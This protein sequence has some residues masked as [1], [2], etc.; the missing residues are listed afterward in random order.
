MAVSIGIVTT[1]YGEPYYGFLDR[2]SAAILGLNTQ[3][4]WITIVH[5][6]VPIDVQAKITKRL[7]PTWILEPRGSVFHPQVHINIGIA[8]TFTDWIV[9]ADVDDLLL[10][11][12]L[13]GV[14]ESEADILSFGYRVGDTDH[15]SRVVSAEAVLQKSSNA[16]GSCSPFR[17]WVWEANRFEDR[18]YD[19]WAFWIKAA[20]A[21][22]V[23]DATGRVDYV[24]SAHPDQISNRI[25]HFLALADVR[26]L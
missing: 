1:V 21:G 4:D 5:D 7:D 25:D 6:G 24:Y 14:R 15:P 20:Q 17:R 11:H 12:A 16:V 3:P 23:F 19:D 9:K 10:P 26:S 18:M 8:V 2:W 13:D 22:A